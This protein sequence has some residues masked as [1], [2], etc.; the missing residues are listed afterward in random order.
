MVGIVT[1]GLRSGLSRSLLRK[2]R[3]LSIL[4]IIIAI[5]ANPKNAAITVLAAISPSSIFLIVLFWMTRRQPFL[6]R[7]LPKEGCGS[8][9]YYCH[10]IEAYDCKHC[11]ILWISGRC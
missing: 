11:V 5:P 1:R 9:G 2:A 8:I 10:E 3:G 4:S 6:L 7:G